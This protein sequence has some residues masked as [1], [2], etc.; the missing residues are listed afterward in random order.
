MR[1]AWV[2]IYDLLQ[3]II[4]KTSPSMRRAWVEILTQTDILKSQNVAL[5][6]E[7]VGRN[8]E[9]LIFLPRKQVA[10]HAEG[11]GRNICE[12]DQDSE[13]HVALHAEGVGRNLNKTLNVFTSAS[14][15]PCGGRG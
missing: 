15:P 12:A 14:R 11:V 8:T 3:F 6:A 1:R 7:G 4:Q 10:L 5:H 13:G 2:E 9:A